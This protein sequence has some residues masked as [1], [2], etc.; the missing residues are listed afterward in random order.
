VS[1]PKCFKSSRLRFFFT[2]Q[3]L[4]I[5]VLHPHSS[6]SILFGSV[7]QQLQVHKPDKFIVTTVQRKAETRNWFQGGTHSNWSSCMLRNPKLI[8]GGDPFQLVLMHVIFQ[9]LF[10]VH[11]RQVLLFFFFFFCCCS[12]LNSSSKCSSLSFYHNKIDFTSQFVTWPLLILSPLNLKLKIAYYRTP[13]IIG[14]PSI[15]LPNKV[16]R[17]PN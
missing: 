5:R 11:F 13:F 16:M 7:S 6:G 2:L 3:L 4:H 10:T 17:F 14:V 1:Y 8:S 15:S 12:Y 9:F